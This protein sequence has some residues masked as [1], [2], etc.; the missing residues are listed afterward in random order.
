M[1]MSLRNPWNLDEDD[2][3]S[4][5]VADVR[6]RDRRK[7]G[8]LPFLPSFQSLA[9]RWPGHRGMV[10]KDPYALTGVHRSAGVVNLSAGLSH[11]LTKSWSWN[12]TD[13]ISLASSGGIFRRTAAA[14]PF[15][16]CD[17]IRSAKSRASSRRA[18]EVAPPRRMK[19]PAPSTR[20][21]DERSE[22]RAPNFSSI[23]VLRRAHTSDTP[24]NPNAF[25]F[26][27]TPS[28]IGT[29]IRV[30]KRESAA[31]GTRSA[32]SITATS[33]GGASSSPVPYPEFQRRQ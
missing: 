27:P 24:S 13:S 7:A 28:I 14:A 11:A 10:E 5:R 19:P 17:A 12:A 26:S 21:V 30:L 22:R 6:T 31:S 29:E 3:G 25:R 1:P 15:R 32:S 4:S 8:G 33:K 23:Q 9:T 2:P 20:N 18:S 16:S